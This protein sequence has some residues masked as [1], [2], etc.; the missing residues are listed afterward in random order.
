MGEDGG[1]ET[2]MSRETGAELSL[3]RDKERACS[4]DG[5][6]GEEKVFKFTKR[7]EIVLT[8]K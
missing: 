4:G 7:P 2:P 5:C 8:Q 6:S 1:G 3:R